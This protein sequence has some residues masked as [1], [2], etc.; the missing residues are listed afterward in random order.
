VSE[1]ESLRKQLN[2]VT[3]LAKSQGTAKDPVV[4]RARQLAVEL[5]DLT[6]KAV[7][8]S[9][10][11]QLT[12]ARQRMS[13]LLS[14]ED[15][16]GVSKTKAIAGPSAEAEKVRNLANKLGLRRGFKSVDE[17]KEAFDKVGEEVISST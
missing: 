17:A 9:G 8:A 12:A 15:L 1:V 10:D 3:D 6:N 14:A 4:A 2:V 7:E 11:D 13:D 16:L 5:R